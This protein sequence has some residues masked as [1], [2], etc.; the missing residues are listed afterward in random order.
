MNKAQLVEQIANDADITKA[1]AQR[2]V[3][4]AIQAI[5]AELST[6]G[7]VA[8]IGFGTFSVSARAARTGRN[9][10]T[11]EPLQIAASNVPKFKAGKLLKD[12]VNT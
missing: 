9:P 2:A 10:K 7:E 11:G 4:A 8:L 3:N 1:A 5:S 6:G 12:A